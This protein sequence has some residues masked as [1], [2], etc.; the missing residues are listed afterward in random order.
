MIELNKEQEKH[1]Q[2]LKWLFSEGN[3]K[4]GRTFLLAVVL[5]NKAVREGEWIWIAD[6]REGRHHT[7]N[8]LDEIKRLFDVHCNQEKFAFEAS[9]LEPRFRIRRLPG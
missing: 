5:V 1:Y 6:H 2:S 3:R 9:S 7:K 4:Q 8:L